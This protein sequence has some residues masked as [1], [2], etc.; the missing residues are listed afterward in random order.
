MKRK[1][2]FVLLDLLFVLLAFLVMAWIKPA[3]K[4]TVLPFYF[5]SFLIFLLVWLVA[6]VVTG[7]YNFKK[8]YKLK[9][10][11]FSVL[12]SNATVTAI[13]TT[14][15]FFY[16][17]F[18]YSRSI[19]FGTIIL[20]TLFE[21]VL[22]IIFNS[23]LTA[24]S[25]DSS[26]KL[27]RLYKQGQKRD[28]S[29]IPHKVTREMEKNFRNGHHNIPQK[30][31]EL[32]QNEYGDNVYQYIIQF[33]TADI[34]LKNVVSTSSQFN[35]LTLVQNQYNFL[36]N[37]HRINDIQ[38]V[39]KFFE[40]VNS[41]LENN[42]IFIGKVET[43]SLRKVKLLKKYVFPL[44]YLIYI[45]DFI[46]KRVFPKIPGFNKVYFAITKGR[47]RLLSRAETFG[48][49]YS[50][51]FVV[52]DEQLIDN[53]LYFVAKKTGE[54][55]FPENPTYGPLVKLKRVGKDGKVFGVYKM[56]TMH[57]YSEYL[58]NYVYEKNQLQE[59]GKFKND[60]RI[61]TVGRLMRK[62]WLDEMPMFLNILKGDMKIVGVRPLSQH[63]FNLYNTEL[64]EKRIKF[65]PGLVPPFYADMPK[66]LDEIMESEMRYLNEYEK[67][68]LRTD[69]KY[70][71]KAWKNIVFKR[72]RSN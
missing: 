37:L 7:K 41:K 54:P 24:K 1:V 43:Y 15:I 53:D 3:T 64:K 63:Y 68:P 69:I 39:N 58:Q 23:I 71:F 66:T 29:I 10:A 67:H 25:I 49:L 2:L 36:V 32:I 47:N 33:A 22:A 5:N 19:V 61:S 65:K 13:V 62:V 51:G 28:Q 31:K 57:P 14:M 46:L 70:F 8:Q 16:R 45:I 26:D 52:E 40:A 59:G 18:G 6:S 72:A 48:R 42:G 20:A 35:I 17:L 27:D 56:R 38:R 9:D 11:F 50:C 60:F 4:S 30:L 21:L 55:L 44:N 34:G 12:I